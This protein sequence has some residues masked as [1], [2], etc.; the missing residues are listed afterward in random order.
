MG[1]RSVTDR[2]R[3]RPLGRGDTVQVKRFV[4][5]F[6]LANYFLAFSLFA[7]ILCFLFIFGIFSIFENN[8]FCFVRKENLNF[9]KILNCG[10]HHV[11][12]VEFAGF[13][14]A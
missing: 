8:L 2:Y 13:F 6:E 4:R 11:L 3:A 1:V 7:Y 9:L 12:S 5:L 14:F 10:D